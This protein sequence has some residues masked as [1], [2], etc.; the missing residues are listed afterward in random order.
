M[1][2]FLLIDNFTTI[3]DVLV[4]SIQKLNYKVFIA[5][6]KE[7]IFSILETNNIDVVLLGDKVKDTNGIE[8]AEQILQN[9]HVILLM[10]S[11]SQDL[12]LKLKAKQAGIMGWI[13]KPFI[14]ERLIKIIIKTYF[15]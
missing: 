13:V 7:K 15:K 6:E 3:L 12:N 10:M 8:L 5:T 2:S 9:W 4:F 14:P 11:Y 1:Y